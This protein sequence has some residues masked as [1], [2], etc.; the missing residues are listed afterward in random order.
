[1]AAY[2]DSDHYK[3]VLAATPG[4]KMMKHRGTNFMGR[5]SVKNSI[6]IRHILTRM[7][8]CLGPW[9]GLRSAANYSKSGKA[10]KMPWGAP[11]SP[12]DVHVVAWQHELVADGLI[13]PKEMLSPGY[14]YLCIRNVVTTKSL[15]A[16]WKSRRA[17]WARAIAVQ[18][19]WLL[20]MD[21]IKLEE[22]NYK[23]VTVI[24]SVTQDTEEEV[25]PV[26]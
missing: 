6:I 25:Q 2:I 11:D 19:G 12:W 8:E 1:M 21:L 14:V 7:C 16:A 18:A 26:L 13:D 17:A 20:T 4:T 15:N 23:D 3:K 24:D 5:T 10:K 22:I 9:D